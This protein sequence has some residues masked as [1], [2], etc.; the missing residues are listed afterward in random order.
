MLTRPSTVQAYDKWST[1]DPIE[2]CRRELHKQAFSVRHPL[3]GHPLFTVEALTK[4]AEQ[5]SKRQGDTY[6]DA[7]DL[8][9]SDKWGSTPK[10][11]MTIPEIIDRIETAGAWLVMKHV[12]I[13]PAYKAVLDEFVAFVR[14]LAG[15]ELSKQMLKPEM[16]VFI[17]SPN[18]KTPYHFDA[19]PNFLVQIQGAK[20]I[21]I[22]DPT[23]RSI[24][25]EAELERYYAV[26]TTAGTY[27]PHAEKT[28]RK[29]TLRPGDA[30]HIP[31]HGAHWVQN[32]NEVSVGLS[33]NFEFP[34]WK[35]GD[36]YIANHYLRRLGVSPRPPGS[37]VIADRSKAG[38]I[39]CVRQ[40]RSM[41]KR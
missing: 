11:D 17:T 24:T 32:H 41:I 22:C 19:E 23:D 39:G 6:W 9:L 29:F 26:T 3:A 28:A 5:A 18:R 34:R 30:V 13:D 35:Y 27:K 40:L 8:T 16:L 38:A 7:G 31:T 25:T 12:E 2:E 4:V 1:V 14:E 15:P 20:D 36:I 33:L 10:P 37:S 21:W